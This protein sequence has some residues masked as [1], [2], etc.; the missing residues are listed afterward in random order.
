MP[1]S[2][3]G[4]GGTPPAEDTQKVFARNYAARLA[5][6]VADQIGS[7]RRPTAPRKKRGKK[8]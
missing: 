2:R 8:G 5:K 4:A 3:K 1:K 7:S 6:Q